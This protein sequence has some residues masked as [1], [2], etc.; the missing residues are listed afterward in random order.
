MAITTIATSDNLAAKLWSK[1]LMRDVLDKMWYKKFIGSDQNSII[2]ILPETKKQRGDKVTYGL[3]MQLSGAGRTGQEVLE[4]NE[5]DL[6]FYDAA[7]YIDLMRNAVKIDTTISQQRTEY[8]LRKEA[9]DALSDWWA[10]RLDDYMFRYLAGDTSLTFAGNT[11]ASA[12]ASHVV[13]AST[14]TAESQMTTAHTFTL[15][16][17]DEAV[18]IAKTVSPLVRPVRIDGDSWWVVVLHPKQ[19]YDLRTS[20]STGAWLDLQKAAVMGGQIKDNPIFKGALGTYNGCILYESNNVHSGAY[21]ASDRTVY[22]SLLLGAQ[23]GCIAF[24]MQGGVDQFQWKEE[25]FDYGKNL[26]VAAS[27]IWGVQKNRFNS[28]DYGAITIASASSQ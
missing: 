17:I 14:C 8:D 24:G 3:R 22:R 19:V 1:T 26:G 5:E 27:L 10:E 23:S 9:R 25:L 28:L 18:L 16:L 7:L 21:G 20:T 15:S 6:T 4:G 11:A 12:D 13:F 2:Q